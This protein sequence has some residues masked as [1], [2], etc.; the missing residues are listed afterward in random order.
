MFKSDLNDLQSF[1][2][3]LRERTNDLPQD[4]AE[5]H[6]VSGLLHV[7]GGEAIDYDRCCQSVLEAAKRGSFPARI[8]YR[9]FHEALYSIY[10]IDEDEGA[11][12]STTS[13]LAIK[14]IDPDLYEQLERLEIAYPDN[15]LAH[16]LR[17]CE[18]WSWAEQVHAKIYEE[19]GLDPEDM[20]FLT[21]WDAVGYAPMHNNSIE[22]FI[23]KQTASL[24]RLFK[25][26]T[27]TSE[28]DID[29]VGLLLSAAI[30][31]GDEELSQL[32]ALCD[33]LLRIE[34][35]LSFRFR[36]FSEDLLVSPLMLACQV[37]NA[38]AVRILHR[39]SDSQGNAM[40]RLKCNG[41][42][43]PLHFLFTF[44]D[45]DVPEMCEL[46]SRG[47]CPEDTQCSLFIPASGFY[48]LLGTPLKFSFRIGSEAALVA[49]WNQLYSTNEDFLK[50]FTI[51][52]APESTN[53]LF[54]MLYE[55]SE[56]DILAIRCLS[57]TQLSTWSNFLDSLSEDS[58]TKMRESFREK[59]TEGLDPETNADRGLFYFQLTFLL[60]NMSQISHML[61]HGAKYTERLVSQIR[62][63]ME[64]F[65]DVDNPDFLLTALSLPIIIAEPHFQVA[66]AKVLE[67]SVALPDGVDYETLKSVI[68]WTCVEA[69]QQGA[70]IGR[71]LGFV[72]PRTQPVARILDALAA[73][74]T[75]NDVPA[76][77]RVVRQAIGKQI[78]LVEAGAI[79]F[80]GAKFAR[81]R[82]PHAQKFLPMIFDLDLPASFSWLA[83]YIVPLTLEQQ[84]TQ[85]GRLL[86][87]AV[88]HNNLDLV[89]LLI[90]RDPTI[91][92]P[93]FFNPGVFYL[94]CVNDRHLSLL[95]GLLENLDP[96]RSLEALNKSTRLTGTNALDVA[97]YH[98]SQQCLVHIA[99][100]F[101]ERGLVP[102]DNH[103]PVNILHSFSH[104]QACTRGITIIFGV[105][106]L[107][108]NPLGI[109]SSAWRSE[110]Q[111]RA[112]RVVALPG[113]LSI[114]HFALELSKESPDRSQGIITSFKR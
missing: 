60:T 40:N 110:V 101:I 107:W 17:F 71:S 66:F 12:Q 53:S 102:D 30:L 44:Q 74:V 50:T 20:N 18:T 75:A 29:L 96:S 37:G 106:A 49:L 112:E 32:N 7:F 77:C 80:L 91:L 72:V 109:F 47:V 81:E 8:I 25:Q 59:P 84:H 97:A 10:S 89:L 9:R 43:I 83:R 92:D 68:F 15:Y 38:Q 85:T 36:L 19:A 41:D 104:L 94:I 76:F 103:F 67:G 58:K 93:G 108:R 57:V 98:G 73:A 111:K 65:N 90:E 114:S 113:N 21:T 69:E 33:F 4:S 86:W 82:L 42:V 34:F 100:F 62:H 105:R 1:P 45:V 46:L 99:K 87:D 26:D 23:Q 51:V 2:G 79:Q 88:K 13:P 11:G 78:N 35:S 56:L 3:M 64:F 95:K 55:M 48:A 5:Y 63:S 14:E 54:S 61:L 22:D 31:F 28:A 27:A 52:S 39:A 70:S 6:L 24:E 16:L